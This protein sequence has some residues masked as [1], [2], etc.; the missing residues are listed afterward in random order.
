[1]YHILKKHLNIAV[2]FLLIISILFGY[3]G[4]PLSK[5]ICRED[6]NVKVSITETT[7][8]CEHHLHK[9]VKRSCCAP[10]EAKDNCCD[11]AH[12][13]YKIYTNTLVQQIKDKADFNLFQTA[14]TLYQNNNFVVNTFITHPKPE[15]QEQQQTL[16]FIQV[17]RI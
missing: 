13:F 12:A 1:M 14:F 9:E 5:M 2:S 4:V 16:P 15:T 8:E 11:Y 17:F 7:E 6:G 10:I 3:A